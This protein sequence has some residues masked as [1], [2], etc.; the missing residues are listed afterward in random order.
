[1][2]RGTSNIRKF[3]MKSKIALKIKNKNETKVYRL[4]SFRIPPKKYTKFSWAYPFNVFL[5]FLGEKQQNRV[6]RMSKFTENFDG[7]V[8]ASMVTHNKSLGPKFSY[9]TA[10]F[11]VCLFFLVTRSSL[12]YPYIY[13]LNY[14]VVCYTV[15]F[16]YRAKNKKTDFV[17]FE[18]K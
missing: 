17:F 15:L 4:P 3:D 6:W 11:L 16:S 8:P 10:F 13:K 14:T 18:L 9:P 2:H 5:T 12:G 7:F 1:M